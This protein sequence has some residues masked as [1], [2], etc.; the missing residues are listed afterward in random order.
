MWDSSRFWLWQ[1]SCD[2][3]VRS[4]SKPLCLLSEQKRNERKETAVSK[5]SVMREMCV[6]KSRFLSIGVHFTFHNLIYKICS[7]TVCTHCQNGYRNVLRQRGSQSIREISYMAWRLKPIPSSHRRRDFIEDLPSLNRR[8]IDSIDFALVEMFPKN[9]PLSGARLHVVQSRQKLEIPKKHP[10]CIKRSP[11][12]SV[13]KL[14]ELKVFNLA[15]MS[16]STCVDVHSTSL[17]RRNTQTSRNY[18]LMN[19]NGIFLCSGLAASGCCN[20]RGASFAFSVPQQL[21]Y[22]VDCYNYLTLVCCTPIRLCGEI[23]I[24]RF[25]DEL[26]CVVVVVVIK[27][28]EEKEI[29]GKEK[30]KE[31]KERENCTWRD[32]DSSDTRHSHWRPCRLKRAK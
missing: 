9:C 24:W 14:I 11:C 21:S 2:G 8:V 30:R 16:C 13:K 6:N 29:K 17:S 15:K 22:P 19:R 10:T 20:G 4:I 18:W 12:V 28:K 23:F 1:Y 3:S 31:E 5:E 27:K 25:V 7:V 32:D 26:V